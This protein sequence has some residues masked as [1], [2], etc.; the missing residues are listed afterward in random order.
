M[1]SITLVSK[2]KSVANNPHLER[3]LA[4]TAKQIISMNFCY[5]TMEKSKASSPWGQC[6]TRGKI[7]PGTGVCGRWHHSC[8]LSPPWG[9]DASKWPAKE[10]KGCPQ[11][12]AHY[13]KLPPARCVGWRV[14]GQQHT[15]GDKLRLLLYSSQGWEHKCYPASQWGTSIVR[16]GWGC[17]LLKMQRHGLGITPWM[18]MW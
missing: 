15:L 18:A 8:Q 16:L 17:I 1:S 9:S 2:I 13:H 12:H 14:L 10:D 4:V 11:N 6:W 3:P 5:V 7:T